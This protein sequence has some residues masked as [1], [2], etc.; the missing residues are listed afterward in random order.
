MKF[1]VLRNIYHK[2]RNLQRTSR[3]NNDLSKFE[4]LRKKINN[5]FSQIPIEIYP[6]LGENTIFTEFDAH[7]FYHPAWAFRKLL[8][9]NP[10]IHYDISSILYFSGMVSAILPVKYYDF[11]PAKIKLSNLIS[12]KADLLCLPFKDNSIDSLS[13]M[14]TLEHIGLGRYGDPINPSGDLKAISELKRVMKEGGNLLL[15]VP[16]G[17]AKIFFNAHR[18]YTFKQIN[19]FFSGFEIK[20]FSLVTDDK[21]FIVNATESQSDLQEYGC[22]CFWFSKKTIG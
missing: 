13:C 11:R 7:Y 9:I 21:S 20:E 2:A 10:Q 15:V 4:Q 18:V 5:E 22:G 6:C 17:K 12:D 3:F 19:E 14:H 8:E 16:V 1:K